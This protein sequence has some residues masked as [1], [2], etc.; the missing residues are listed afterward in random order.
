MVNSITKK[1]IRPNLIYKND[2]RVDLTF[3]IFDLKSHQL[4]DGSEKFISIFQYKEEDNVHLNDLFLDEK[5]QPLSVDF[6]LEKVNLNVRAYTKSKNGHYHK[7]I[8]NSK[9]S[10]TKIHISFIL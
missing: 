8:F 3:A 2:Q 1:F 5:Y 9:C 10:D 4:I 7:V 6:F